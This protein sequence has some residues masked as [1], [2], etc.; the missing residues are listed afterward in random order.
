MS[1]LIPK[2]TA[3]IKAEKIDALQS[4]LQHHVESILS[5]IYAES[6]TEGEQQAIM[7]VFGTGASSALAK[8]ATLHA[9]IY[10]LNP[11]TSLPVPN[12]T[13]FQPQQD[14]TVNYVAP[15]IPEPAP[16]P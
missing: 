11:A 16:Q 3:Q 15:P 14:G 6:N 13:V 7:D 9:A 10:A 8:Y 5:L 12:L 2:T 1:S 4:E